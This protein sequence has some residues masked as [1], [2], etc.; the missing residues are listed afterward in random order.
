[1][2]EKEKEMREQVEGTCDEMRLAL[3]AA[4][5]EANQLRSEKS[6][7]Q[8]RVKRLNQKLGGSRKQHHKVIRAL[9]EW[10]RTVQQADDEDREDANSDDDMQSGEF[11]YLM[12]SP[13]SN[14]D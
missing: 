8:Y 11:T 4:R 6:R 10:R 7:L 2:A 3:L 12:P 1:M 14:S 13:T 9:G 5:D